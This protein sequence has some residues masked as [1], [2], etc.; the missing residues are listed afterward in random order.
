MVHC[1]G[2]EWVSGVR[3]GEQKRVS[4]GGKIGWQM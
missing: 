4:A 2:I 3:H 1:I